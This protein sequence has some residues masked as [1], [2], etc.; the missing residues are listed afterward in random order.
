MTQV[1]MI[2][3]ILFDQHIKDSDQVERYS[4]HSENHSYNITYS[5]LLY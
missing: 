3:L 1:C 2:T 5:T 4:L